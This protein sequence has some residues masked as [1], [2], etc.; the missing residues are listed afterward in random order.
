MSEALNEIFQ[1]Q[2]S[3]IKKWLDLATGGDGD[4]NELP[5]RGPVEG[6]EPKS[7]IVC[8]SHPR[9]PKGNIANCFQ[10]GFFAQGRF[11]LENDDASDYVSCLSSPPARLRLTSCVVHASLRIHRPEDGRCGISNFRVSDFGRPQPGGRRHV[12]RA[13]LCILVSEAQFSQ[14]RIR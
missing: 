4:K 5:D 6:G 12:Q 14:E 7:A 9:R 13:A 2:L 8:C 1:G 3:D 10:S 11:I